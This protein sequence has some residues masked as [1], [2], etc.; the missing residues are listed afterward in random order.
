[1]RIKFSA[2]ADKAAWPGGAPCYGAAVPDEDRAGVSG[3][4]RQPQPSFVWFNESMAH[5]CGLKA[6][7]VADPS[8]STRPFGT[9]ATFWYEADT[10]IETATRGKQSLDD[11]LL[12][13]LRGTMAPDGSLR[14]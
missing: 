9:E 4:G 12:P 1:M 3:R 11:H 5:Y 10:A 7:S 2:A 6:L 13:L 8:P 14:I